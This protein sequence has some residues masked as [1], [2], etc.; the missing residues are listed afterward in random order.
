MPRRARV[1]L[2]GFHHVYNRA[3]EKKF[4][5]EADEDKEKFL[6][7]LEETCTKYKFNVHSY[8]VMDNHYHILLETTLDN[9]SLGM[10][11]LNSQ[12]AIYYNKKYKRV[13][14]LWQDRFKSWYI[15]DENY[16]FAL[17]RYIELNPVAAKITKKIGQYRYASSYDILNNRVKSFLNNSFVLRDYDTK[18]FYEVLQID[19]NE[20]DIE[21]I[22]KIHK[23]KISI[24]NDD[25]FLEKNILLS[26]YFEDIKNKD[27][28]NSAISEAFK[29]GYKQ[30]EIAKFL[31]LSVSLVS[32]II[33]IQDSTPDPLRLRVRVCFETIKVKDGKLL[34]LKYHQQRVDKTREHFGFRD[35]L[36]LKEY[37]FDLP[38]KGE[39]RLRVDY[40]KDIESFACKAFTCREFKEFR[41]VESDVE[42]DYKY[43]NR[44]ELDA[45]KKDDKEIIIIK[46]GLLT[47]TTIANIAL[48]VDGIWLTPKTPLLYGTTRARLIDSGF[49]KCK[50]LTPIDLKKAQNFAIMNALIDFRTIRAEIELGLKCTIYK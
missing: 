40:D 47:D 11:Q 8:V 22:D 25:I 45:L 17:Y 36:E 34:N 26:V 21:N 23:A 30:S 16:L 10:R 49:L 39:F 27:E 15:L 19:L 18:E 2:A 32:K 43:A 20:E 13:G 9:I 28:R 48:H 35:K 46:N 38:Q 12:Y 7:I 44:D 29:N 4:V 33:K 1:E 37:N 6:E 41:V 31:G 24:K 50:D 14:H 42:Y 3:V 5:L